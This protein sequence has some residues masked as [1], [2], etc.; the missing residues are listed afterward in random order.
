MPKRRSRTLKEGQ[1]QSLKPLRWRV[2]TRM[3]DHVGI[4]MYS[5]YPKAIAELVVN[6]YDADANH[7]TVDIDPNTV[8]ISG[9][10]SG[11]DE[12]DI[13][14]GYMFLGSA[15]KRAVKR[16]PVY[17]RLP[18]GNKG[19]GKLAGLGIANRMEVRT[20]KGGM[21]HVFHIDRDALDVSERRG[22][23]REAVLDNAL[24]PISRFKPPKGA[25]D[26]TTVILTDIRRETGRMDAGRVRAYLARELPLG[27][28]FKVVVQGEVCRASHV[29]AK[30][31]VPVDFR[32]PVC[33]EVR[34]EIRI[35][36][37]RLTTGG[38][39]TTVRGRVVGGPSYFGV[40]V[41]SLRHNVA[42]FV[43]GTMEVTGF[44]PEEDENGVPVIK[45]DREGFVETHPRYQA[46]SEAMTRLLQGIFREL[47]KEFD[48]K[49][50]ADR[51]A[52]VDE[53]IKRAAEDLAAYDKLRHPPVG[54]G[55]KL[56]GRTD[57]DGVPLSHHRYLL[58]GGHGNGNGGGG[59]NGQKPATVEEVIPATLGSGRLRFNTVPYII[60]QDNL[61]E[62]RPECVVRREEQP[63]VIVVNVNH[64]A[65]ELGIEERC[66]HVTVF[67]A[68]AGAL[69]AA[70][71]DSS[72]DMYDY[73]DDMIRFQASRMKERKSAKE[74][75]VAG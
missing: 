12:K 62:L 28:D 38:I 13:R 20:I 7:V 69:A 39:F 18:I 74:A 19:I 15:Q 40:T 36:R 57:E 6:E 54:A 23:L 31:V 70:E 10:G 14:E 5:Q 44:D 68:I 63:P 37:S 52:K 53:A 46:Y 11:M 61:G 60:K 22:R 27:P 72:S 24:V 64:P 21:G 67:R 30:R 71:T 51:R 56:P 41:S 26:G 75:T 59:G 35:A 3:L 4:S 45:T 9:N 65:Y 43:T 1:E 2:A 16:T 8:T 42:N 73:L 29:D 33:G 25:A 58:P 55:A 66:V 17:H 34:G 32:D 47:E 49:R 48:E 50:E